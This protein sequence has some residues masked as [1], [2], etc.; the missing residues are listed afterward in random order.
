[1]S[2]SLH[3]VISDDN[4]SIELARRNCLRAIFQADTYQSLPTSRNLIYIYLIQG[5]V[6]CF[7]RLRAEHKLPA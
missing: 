1:M 6:S 2:H 4:E 5:S 7:Q 3:E